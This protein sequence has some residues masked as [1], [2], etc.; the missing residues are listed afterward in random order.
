VDAHPNKELVF[1]HKP[2]KTLIE[3]DLLFS[4]PAREQYSKTGIDPTTGWATR[5]F[6]ALQN[7]RGE[8]LWQKRLLW[9][10]ISSADS[11]GLIRVFRGLIRGD[12]RMWCRVTGIVLWGM[13]R[14][15]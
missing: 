6:A 8:A 13:G 7:T 3:A 12:L 15:F 10:A 14:G 1:F 2:S 5:I 11:Q 4:L 9:Y